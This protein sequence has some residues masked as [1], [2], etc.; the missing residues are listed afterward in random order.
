MTREA[1]NYG[2]SVIRV[3]DGKVIDFELE[4][5]LQVAKDFVE[6]E[7]ARLEFNSVNS[8]HKYKYV[9]MELVPYHE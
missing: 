8:H 4:P 6:R 7:N 5:D 9:V 3:S 1:S 2:T